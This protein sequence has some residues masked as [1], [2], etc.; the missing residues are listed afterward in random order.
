MKT[1]AIAALILFCLTATLHGCAGSRTY[2]IEVK[3]I[4]EEGSPRNSLVEGGN[5]ESFVVEA[6]SGAAITEAVYG[7]KLVAFIGQVAQKKV[8]IRTVESE[9]KTKG[10]GFDIVEVR[11]RLSTILTEVIREIF[12]DVY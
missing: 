8:V 4:G 7:V 5:I 1:N 2:L 11:H 9:P 3:Y 6:R 12:K 10:M